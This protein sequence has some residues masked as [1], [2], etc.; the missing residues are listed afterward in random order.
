M[1]SIQRAEIEWRVLPKARSLLSDLR[2]AMGKQY[3]EEKARL[4]D[5]LCAYFSQGTCTDRQGNSIAPIK[6][7]LTAKGGKV[8]KVRWATPGSGKSGGLRLAV[9]VYCEQ[10]LVK[11]AGA[12][13]RRDDPS[14]EDFLAATADS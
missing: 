7:S 4:Q 3:E 6:S 10:K 14:D 11:V 8:L 1:V 12:W 13:H 9:I 2:S 5:F